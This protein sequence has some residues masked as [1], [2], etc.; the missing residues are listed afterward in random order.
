MQ[1]LR[2]ASDAVCFASLRS[3][4]VLTEQ[5]L[6]HSQGFLAV[7][8]SRRSTLRNGR[9]STSARPT[10]ATGV[11]AYDELRTLQPGART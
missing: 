11:S 8:T 2:I 6:T 10:G 1:W 7:K 5:K 4:D 3:A 9:Q